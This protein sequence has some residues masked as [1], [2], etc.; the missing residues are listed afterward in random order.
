MTD[1]VAAT[2]FYMDDG[3]KIKLN[4]SLYEYANILYSKI[5]E[6][7][8][9]AAYRK[10]HDRKNRVLFC[11]FFS[12]RMKQSIHNLQT[13]AED[14]IAIDARYVYE[15]YPSISRSQM[16]SLVDAAAEAWD[17]HILACLSCP[18][19]CLQYSYDLTPMFDNLARTGWPT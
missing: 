9:L 8:K 4:W 10:R 18:V 14:G 11:V 6:S 19:Q 15:F 3:D 12:K 17:E 7:K 2:F 1:A 16:S 13:G 5:E